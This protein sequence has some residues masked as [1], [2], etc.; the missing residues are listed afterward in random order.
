M[1]AVTDYDRWRELVNTA[2][3]MVP[4]ETLRDAAIVGGIARIY[5]AAGSGFPQASLVTSSVEE[6]LMDP[7][8]KKM[9]QHTGTNAPKVAEV[10][11]PIPT[12][13][14]VAVWRQKF[15]SALTSARR[16]LEATE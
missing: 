10:L 3:L 8:W 4:T 1:S 16:L 15:S 5:R 12:D 9:A 7:I 2:A 14:E 11:S 13:E 6:F